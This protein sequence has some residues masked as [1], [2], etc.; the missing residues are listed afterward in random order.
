VALDATVP[1]DNVE[2][3]NTGLELSWR[4]ILFGR[5]GYKSILLDNSEQG[6]TWGVGVHYGITNVGTIKLDYGFAD[7]GRLKNVQYLSLGLSL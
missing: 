6:L 7:Y 3:L 5:V 4:Q 2:Y 1:N